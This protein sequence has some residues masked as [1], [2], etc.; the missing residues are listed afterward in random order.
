MRKLE[1]LSETDVSPRSE[2]VTRTY[3][4]GPMTGL[5]DL[6]FPA[7]HAAAAQLRAAGC[8]PVNPAEINPD[9]NAEWTDC[10]FRDLEELTKCDAILLLDG[11]QKSPGAQIERLWAIRTGKHIQYQTEPVNAD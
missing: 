8:E 4:A 6:N 5:P 2:G 7:F 3:I 9:P 11:W 10:M 1:W